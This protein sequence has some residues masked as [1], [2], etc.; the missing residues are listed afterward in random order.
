MARPLRIEYP[1][2]VY[3]VLSRGV[4][5]RDIFQQDGDYR[6]FLEKLA[7]NTG[8]FRVK[9]R[10]YCLMTNHFHLYLQTEEANLSK[11]MQSLLTSYAALKNRRDR[12]LGHL[13]QGRFKAHLVDAEGYGNALSRYIHLNPV[14]VKRVKPLPIEERQRLLRTYPWSSYAAGIGLC[15]CPAWLDRAAL[16]LTW[17]ATPKEKQEHYSRYVEEGLMREIE[18]PVAAAAAQCIIGG[19]DF[20]DWVR[21][22]Y[23]NVSERTNLRRDQTQAVTLRGWV[24]SAE[25]QRLVAEA[26]GCPPESLLPRYQHGNE[27]RQVLVYLAAKYCRGRHSLVEISEW[28]N[29][30]I[31]GLTAGRR[32][33]GRRQQADRGF[34]QRVQAIEAHLDAR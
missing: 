16:L 1:G 26:Y 15:A 4:G 23:L 12:R 10:S 7:E 25:L 22:T 18:D 11:F 24:S 30:S 32:I 2:A 13:F 3:H 31:G 33:C 21:R 6:S 5:R 34:R 14:R 8:D 17:G 9:I 29:I 28:L 19:D 20:V 27:A